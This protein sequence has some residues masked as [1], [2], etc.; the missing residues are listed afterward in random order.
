MQYTSFHTSS[1]E[2][3]FARMAESADAGLV[4][5]EMAVSV[6]AG[7][8]T[9]HTDMGNVSLVPVAVSMHCGQRSRGVWCRVRG[10]ILGLHG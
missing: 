2:E 1:G 10:V 9:T 4:S 5:R 7:E 3:V 6:A 8:G